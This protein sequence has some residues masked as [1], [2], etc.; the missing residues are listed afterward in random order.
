MNF[1][2]KLKEINTI[3]GFHS[4]KTFALEIDKKFEEIL[5]QRYNVKNVHLVQENP[6]EEAKKAVSDY[7]NSF[8]ETAAD[9]K[10]VTDNFE[11]KEEL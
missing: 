9:V 11:T 6:Q 8:R 7:M 1:A 10:N 5:K 2:E 4:A 3:S